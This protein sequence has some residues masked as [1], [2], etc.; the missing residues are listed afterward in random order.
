MGEKI[1]EAYVVESAKLA[2]IE[3]DEAAMP[4][5]T[6]GLQRIADFAALLDGVALGVEDEP[7]PVWRP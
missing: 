1:D 7:A 6:A 2:G 5:V 4:G 3:I